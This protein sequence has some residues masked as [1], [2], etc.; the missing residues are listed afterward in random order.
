MF[1][2]AP[3]SERDSR[4]VISSLHPE[5]MDLGASLTLHQRSGGNALFLEELCRALR[6]D[7]LA[8]AGL[9]SASSVPSTVQGVIQVRVAA[10]PPAQAELLRAA[11]VIGIEFSHALLAEVAGEA[12]LDGALDFLCENDWIYATALPGS[13]RFKHGITRD[14]VYATV[15]V[16]ERRRMHRVIASVLERCLV[17][18]DPAHAETLAYHHRG[19]GDYERAGHFAEL[20]G[21]RALLA[22]SLDRALPLSGGAVGAR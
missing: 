15:L 6:D 9:R 10:L 7:S 21:D 19:A 12:Q 20:A 13:Y 1:Q 2:L 5:F 18:L 17:A 11:S 22:S 3:F 8:E 4:A 14:V 16:G